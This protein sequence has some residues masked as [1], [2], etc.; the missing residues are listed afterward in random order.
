MS[1]HRQCTYIEQLCKNKKSSNV[2]EV[3]EYVTKHLLMIGKVLLHLK[4]LGIS[5]PAEAASG[6]AERL[7]IDVIEPSVCKKNI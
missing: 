3:E 2:L 6:S 4:M 5:V 7:F 1:K